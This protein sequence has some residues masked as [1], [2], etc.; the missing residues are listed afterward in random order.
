MSPLKV[1]LFYN[2]VQ[3]LHNGK[4]LLA[5]LPMPNLKFSPW[6]WDPAELGWDWW[7]VTFLH[8]NDQRFRGWVTW[9]S[10]HICVPVGKIQEYGVK[11]LAACF[12]LG[13]KVMVLYWGRDLRVG[14]CIGFACNKI[15]GFSIGG[16]SVFVARVVRSLLKSWCRERVEFPDLVPGLGLS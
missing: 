11:P 12:Q 9:G 5:R 14:F 3:T 2:P 7:H 13:S 15:L 10:V 6:F 8:N 16:M 4:W 1:V